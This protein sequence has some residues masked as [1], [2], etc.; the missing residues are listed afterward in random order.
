MDLLNI[1]FTEE[2]SVLTKGEMSFTLFENTNMA[3]TRIMYSYFETRMTCHRG[4]VLSVSDFGTRGS[5]SI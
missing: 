3:K 1:S 5:G 4:L 2:S